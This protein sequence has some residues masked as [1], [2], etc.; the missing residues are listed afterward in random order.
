MNKI[1]VISSD[2]IQVNNWQEMFDRSR[3]ETRLQRV[4]VNCDL[5]NTVSAG[6][7]LLIYHLEEGPEKTARLISCLEQKPVGIPVILVAGNPT[8]RLFQQFEY[9]GT[10]DV[11]GT[12][13]IERLVLVVRRELS[14]QSLLR[15]MAESRSITY[16][17]DQPDSIDLSDN[18]IAFIADGMHMSVN[19]AYARLFGFSNTAALDSRPLLDLIA[20]DY[21]PDFRKLIQLNSNSAEQ[22]I[23]VDCKRR[24]GSTFKAMLVFKPATFEGE[25]CLQL[26]VDNLEFEHKARLLSEQDP[27]TG[28]YSRPHFMRD[29]QNYFSRKDPQRQQVS[30]LYIL[31]DGFENMKKQHG[32][33]KADQMLA[34]LA[35]ILRNQAKSNMQPYRYGDHAFTVIIESDNPQLSRVL[36]E[37]LIRLISQHRFRSMPDIMPP[38]LS[39]GISN[40]QQLEAESPQYM[41]DHILE[42]AYQSCRMIYENAGNGFMDY[43]ALLKMREEQD[44]IQTI[45]DTTHLR[46][47]IRYAIEHDRFHLLYQPVIS[48][49]GHT[50]EFYSVL[51]RLL[52]NDGQ[53]IR[54]QFFVRQ[55][56]GY[57]L[58][59]KIDRWVIR[60]AIQSL[61]I[62]RHAGNR[63]NFFIQLSQSA[64]GDET[65]LLWI[66][67]CLRD[68]NAK[69]SWITFQFHYPDIRKQ[70]PAVEKLFQGLK[71]INCG[72][73]INQFDNTSNARKLLDILPVDYL[74]LSK[75]L[76]SQM[77][78]NNQDTE[79]ATPLGNLREKREI[80]TIVHD[81]ENASDLI[82][83]W[84]NGI[85]FVQGAFLHEPVTSIING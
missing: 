16:V 77:L 69:G 20:D 36:A 67:D 37:T 13:D 15:E 64:I 7:E 34:E 38:T 6:S 84:S 41:A 75:T 43:S 9:L 73:A 33:L 78:E 31:I 10:R 24:D 58:M 53:E 81:I 56:I 74:K 60:H 55:A 39:I 59:Q 72:I 71:K 17:E 82:S 26:Q 42:Y 2:T 40:S 48:T 85:H 52:D 21:Q 1:L 19:L 50:G 18:P 23:E 35:G 62:Q 57:G 46:E 29:L 65:L 68:N 45:D 61:A 32:L 27:D 8:T 14:N 25:D 11:V 30:L 49:H 5:N 70:Q 66:V 63:V 51:L 79:Q 80:N 47:L 54:P 76:I 4:D 3:L 28:L 83:A 44:I 22:L 12:T